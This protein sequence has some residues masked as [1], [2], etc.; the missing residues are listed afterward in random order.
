[1]TL[2]KPQ[3]FEFKVYTRPTGLGTGTYDHWLLRGT[4]VEI[5][6]SLFEGD[7][8][9]ITSTRKNQDVQIDKVRPVRFYWKNVKL[10][11]GCIRAPKYDN[12]QNKYRDLVTTAY[13]WEKELA[14][15][16]LDLVTPEGVQYTGKSIDFIL[17]DLAR[18]A[19]DMGM[20]KKAS[21]V[22]DKTKLPYYDSGV[23]GT[24]LTRTYGDTIWSALTDLTKELDI[25]ETYHIGEWTVRV[26]ALQSDYY[27]YIIPMM[28]NTDQ[29]AARKF[30]ENMLTTPKGI[31]RDYSRLLNYVGVRGA[32]TLINTRFRPV[33]TLS[34]TNIVTN[35]DEFYADVQPS[36]RAYLKV[37]IKNS[38][39]SDKGGFVTVNGSDGQMNELTERLFLWVKAG[40][41]QVHFTNNRYA[42]LSGASLKAFVTES[43]GGCTI[44]V[45]EASNALK[46]SEIYYSVAGRSINDFGVRGKTI[47]NINFDTQL[48]VDAYAG[49]LVRMYHAPLVHIDAAIKPEYADPDEL[50][51]KTVNMYDNF[52]AGFS[53]FF[54]TKQKYIFEGPSV[55]ESITA[56]RYNYDWEYGE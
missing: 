54:C 56:T 42:T 35:S 29:H 50:I 19:N 5:E 10:F 22:Y 25:A 2:T 39:A 15:I 7:L 51:G 38:T 48:K 1:M 21:Y 17:S 13:G 46:G 33:P 14:A 32:G 45:E 27:I 24:V 34:E 31:R 18:I 47:R 11:D 28:V 3:D 41:E 9:T 44:K 4:V 40:Q 53:D 43:W 6:R 26:D 37:T 55:K 30:K 12:R 20:T 8:L 36:S 23:F 52:Q 49:Q 16:R